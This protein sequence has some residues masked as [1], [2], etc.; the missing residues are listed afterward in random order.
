MTRINFDLD[1]LR[2]FVTGVELG[3]FARAADRLGRSTSAVSAQLKKLEEQAGTPVLRREGRGMALTEPGETLLAY[4]R[5]LLELNDEAASAL[6]GAA[7]EGR[8]RLG[9]QED[10]GETLLPTVL[11]RFSRAHPKVRI[12]VRTAR[13]RQL[14][15]DMRAGELDLALAWDT[16]ER[17]PHMERLGAVRQCWIGA[18]NVP[19]QAGDGPLPLVMLEA[20][21]LLR[22][23]ATEALDRAGIAWR[24]AFTS[25][26]LSGIWAAVAAGLGIG[27]RTP[28]GLPSHVTRLD[29]SHYGLPEMAALG[30]CLHSTDATP[31]PVVA[32]LREMLREPAVEL[33]EHHASS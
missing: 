7:L 23:A 6:R 4:A 18:A 28:V 22:S 29:A 32:R 25:A 16:G 27:L 33:L 10:F 17:T 26:G 14:L 1:V 5:R 12:E 20:P 8:V 31:G 2:T 21:C 9:M 19:F 24:V 30:V 11:G 13:N 3:S 15:Q